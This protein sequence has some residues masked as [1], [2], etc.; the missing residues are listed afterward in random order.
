MKNNSILLQRMIIII[1]FVI[2]LMLV[3]FGWF[4]KNFK[5]D[6]TIMKTGKRVHYRRVK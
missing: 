4:Y 1:M 2:I 6:I 3:P 5:R